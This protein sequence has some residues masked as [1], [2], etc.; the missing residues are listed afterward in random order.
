MGSDPVRGMTALICQ[1]CLFCSVAP[2]HEQAHL[3]SKI[4][5]V[6]EINS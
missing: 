5:T 1:L 4:L 2:L 3:L 6:S